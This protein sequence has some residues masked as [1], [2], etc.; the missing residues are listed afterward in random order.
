MSY[1]THPTA[2]PWPRLRRTARGRGPSPRR[3][4]CSAWPVGPRA[5]PPA[6]DG[7]AGRMLGVPILQLRFIPLF[8]FLGFCFPSSCLFVWFSRMHSSQKV[9]HG[10]GVGWLSS[11]GLWQFYTGETN[12]YPKRPN[13]AVW[14]RCLAC[15][16]SLHISSEPA[17]F[18][19]RL[20]RGI[21]SIMALSFACSGKSCL[22]FGYLADF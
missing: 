2:P 21:Q 6:Q 17:R 4:C 5:P 13:P 7:G 22:L 8:H 12:F 3:C 19:N 14:I 20:H 9:F 11:R 16:L 15:L 10:Y 18:A 1:H